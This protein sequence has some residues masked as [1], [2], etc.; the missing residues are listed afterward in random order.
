MKDKIEGNW[1]VEQAYYYDEPVIWD[2]YFASFELNSDNT[3]D[4]PPI[5]QNDSLGLN[6]RHGIWD[7]L[8]I[9]ESYFIHIKTDNWLF[10]RK[11]QIVNMRVVQ[12]SVSYGYFL[13]MSILSDSL[14]IDCKKII[15]HP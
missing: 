5:H 12:D 8:K 1:Y 11:F 13:K 15:D 6:E 3:C 10:N 9:D 4:L 2:L 7:L 14:R